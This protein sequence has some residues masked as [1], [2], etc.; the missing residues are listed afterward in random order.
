[1]QSLLLPKLYVDSIYHI[2]LDDLKARGIDTIV[3]DLDNT[4][5]PWAESEVNQ[6]LLDWLA[7]V[8]KRGFKIC[9]LSNALEQRLAHFRTAMGV[10]GLSKAN[11]PSRRA[12]LQA[13]EML[14]SQPRETAMIGDQVFTDVLG[15]NRLG[16]YTI[17]VVPLCR[18]EFIG[19]RILRLLE[20]L[21]IRKLLRGSEGSQRK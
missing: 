5:V 13:L 15:G 10:P 19:T 3:T 8:Q 9:L 6:S 2:D 1:M 17:L 14:G 20:R 7:E 12:F 18:Q 4:L 21:V 16:L 11:K